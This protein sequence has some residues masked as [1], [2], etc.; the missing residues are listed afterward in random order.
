MGCPVCPECIWQLILPS[1]PHFIDRLLQ[2]VL[3]LLVRGFFLAVG[4]L[5]VWSCNVVLCPKLLQEFSEGTINEMGPSITYRHSWSPEM[6]EDDLMKHL[7]GM[8][9]IGS[10]ACVD[11]C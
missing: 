9:G 2:N 8:V 11:G 10:S 3:D 6:W 1:F 7:A 5:V 4:L